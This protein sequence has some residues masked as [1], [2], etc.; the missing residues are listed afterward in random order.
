MNFVNCKYKSFIFEEQNENWVFH[1][2]GKLQHNIANSNDANIEDFSLLL[3]LVLLHI[4]TLI[5]IML[6][7]RGGM[8]SFSSYFAHTYIPQCIASYRCNAS[9]LK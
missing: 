1:F 5:I 7:A 4:I 6:M 9:S 3:L 8:D 2:T